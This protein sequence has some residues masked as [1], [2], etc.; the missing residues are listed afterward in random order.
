ME[1]GS[2]MKN[3]LIVIPFGIGDVLFSTPMIAAIKESFPGVRVSYFTS[4]RSA[5]FLRNDPRI[6][7]VFAYDRDDFVAVYRRSPWRFVLK[8]KRLVDDL[9]AGKFEVAF[10]LSMNAGIGAALMLAGI[11]RRIGYNYKGRGRF[12]TEAVALRGYENRHVARHHFELLRSVGIDKAPGPTAFFIPEQDEAWASR[13][14]LENGI[15]GGEPFGVFLG[16]GAS[17]GKG[18]EVRRWPPENYAKFAEKV[19]EKT[20]R[21]VI[22]ISGPA[23]EEICLSVAKMMKSRPVMASRTSLGGAAALMKRCRL[24]ALNDGGAIHVAASCGVRMAVVFGPVDPAVYGP[25]SKTEHIS[26]TKGLPCQPCYR[27]FRMSDCRHQSCLRELT[28][29]EVWGKVEEF[30]ERTR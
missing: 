24:V 27:N 22:L 18:G 12:L 3:V 30:L 26:V 25:I 20:A 5:D 10:D 11:P 9:K 19:I 17:F 29:E 6:E 8:W 15:R 1:I 23:D 4:G 2:T 7:K 28:V 16:G 14:F 21:P 13:F